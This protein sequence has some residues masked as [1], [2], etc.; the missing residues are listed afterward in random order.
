[1]TTNKELVTLTCMV[2]GEEYEGPEPEM[3]CD[4]RECGCMGMPIDPLVCSDECYGKLLNGE[5][6]SNNGIITPLDL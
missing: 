2:C 5:R 3:C 4:G 1:M 6:Y